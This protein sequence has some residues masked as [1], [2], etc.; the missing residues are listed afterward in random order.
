MGGAI[1]CCL[2][3]KRMGGGKMG[4]GNMV[5]RVTQALDSP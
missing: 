4:C 3:T 5:A 2:A 1:I